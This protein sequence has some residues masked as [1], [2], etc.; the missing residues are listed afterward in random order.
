[1][2]SKSNKASNPY[3]LLLTLSDKINFKRSDMLLYDIFSI[4]YS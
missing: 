4:Y 1:M 2:N 3:R